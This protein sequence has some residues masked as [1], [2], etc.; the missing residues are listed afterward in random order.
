MQYNTVCC[1]VLQCVAVCC[2]VLQ[3]AHCNTL[4][5]TATHHM[6]KCCDSYTYILMYILL[7]CVAVCCSVLQCVAVCCS[8]LQCVTHRSTL[9]VY[10]CHGTLFV[11]NTLQ[12]TATHCNTLQHTA[13]HCNTL[14]CNTP[15]HPVRALLKPSRSHNI[16]RCVAVCCSI[17]VSTHCGAHENVDMCQARSQSVLQF[18][19]V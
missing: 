16:L 3:C 8:V 14:Q 19:A 2:S 12:H 13:T 1:S 18:V 5:H 7:Q 9:L 11:H 17:N 15:Q 6:S 4:Q 10:F